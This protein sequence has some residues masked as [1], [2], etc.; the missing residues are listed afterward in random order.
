MSEGFLK[1]KKRLL[2]KAFVKS[3]IFALS[4]A[5]LTF[6]AILLTQKLTTNS[7][8]LTQPIIFGGA[9]LLIGFGLMLLIL[10]PRNKSVAKK[11]DKEFSLGEKT[12]T[13]LEFIEDEADMSVIQREDTNSRLLAI[14]PAAFKEK[15]L[16]LHIIAPV[17]AIAIL[18]PA[19]LVPLK[20][21]TPPNANQEEPEYNAT[22]WQ[23][24]AVIELIEYVTN[25]KLEDKPKEEVVASLEALLLSL[26]TPRPE[27]EL[28]AYVIGVIIDVNASID[29][30]NT[31]NEIALALLE[32]ENEYVKNLAA[33]LGSLQSITV[34]QELDHI[35]SKITKDE[36]SAVAGEIGARLSPVAIVDGDTLYPAFIKFAEDYTYISDNM[37]SYTDAWIS[38]NISGAHDTIYGSISVELLCQYEN[39]VVRKHVI[40]RLVEIF[41][42]PDELIPED[43][44]ISLGT[45]GGDYEYGEQ[46]K[47]EHLNS[48]GYGNADQL[49]GSN[50]TIYDPETN[51]HV[52]YGEVLNAYY[53]KVKEQ[54]LAGSASDTLAAFIDAYF[55]SLY[56]GSKKD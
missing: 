44:K 7:F 21:V 50:D 22:D 47:D 41:N 55:S 15:R 54:L 30:V 23:K 29:S 8:N 45:V 3:G 49:F 39:D 17:L 37:S 11:L 12:Q 28:H 36:I 51:T 48:G 27:S 53:A 35:K 10:Y 43:V 38:N 52:S 14:S 32:S 46:D 9:S 1:I 26:D 31:Y 19:I 5:I 20:A 40:K 24:A 6:S 16:I 33:A 42:I 2:V 34:K 13:M 4:L 25:S 18:I 56:D